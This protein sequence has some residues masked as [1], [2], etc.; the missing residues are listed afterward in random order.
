MDNSTVLGTSIFKTRAGVGGNISR[1]IYNLILGGCLFWGFIFN[2]FIVVFF[3]DAIF[4]FATGGAF[5]Y[6]IFIV[7]YFVLAIAGITISIKS[8]N[9]ATSFLGYNM[10][11]L[12]LGAV[13]SIVLKAYPVMT[14]SYAFGATT[15]LTA[16]MIV[17]S[18]M[19]PRFFLSIGRGLFISLLC[20]ILIEF[21]A[22]FFFRINFTVI[23]IV[24]A[25]IFC[26]YIGFD[27]ARAQMIP[28]TVDNA[29][30]S[31]CALYVDIVN[32]FVRLLRIFGRAR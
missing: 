5:N 7:A 15:I 29:I 23:D 2:L 6:I 9:P 21:V 26:G 22:I 32:L 13:L 14:I 8:Q 31:A 4:S 18:V 17:L 16:L 20:I 30:D 19:F 25:V 12:P 1:R 10:V 24:V 27:W 11:V 28:S 3:G